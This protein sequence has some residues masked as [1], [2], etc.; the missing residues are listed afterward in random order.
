MAQRTLT[1]TGRIEDAAG[2]GVAGAPGSVQILSPTGAPAIDGN[3]VEVQT[4]ALPFAAGADGSYS[5]VVLYPGDFQT[6]G[7]RIR[8]V[9]N[10]VTTDSPL[11]FSYASSI[12]VSSWY[13]AAPTT[14]KVRMRL[15]YETDAGVPIAGAKA[16]IQISQM[17]VDPNGAQ[18]A[19]SAAGSVQGITDS[20]GTVAFW[21]WPSSVLNPATT[22]Y[23]ARIAGESG[24]LT[25]L[26]PAAADY[27]RGQYDAGTTYSAAS[28]TSSGDVAL[29]GGVLYR[30]INATPSAGHD[31]ATSPTYWQ[32]VSGLPTDLITAHLTA[33]AAAGTV[34]LG[35]GNIVASASITALADDPIATPA[36]LDDDLAILAARAGLTLRTITANATMLATDDWVILDAS[37]GNVT[38]TLLAASARVRPLRI[39]RKDGTANTVSIARAGSDVI[40]GATSLALNTQYLWAVLKPDTAH[41]AWYAQTGTG[42]A[43]LPISAE[44][45]L[46]VGN[47]AG[48]ATR[49][50]IGAAGQ[51]PSPVG[52]D[53]QW[54]TPS[55]RGGFA[56]P[57]T[58]DG[59]LLYRKVTLRTALPIGFLG[60]SITAGQGVSPAPPATCAADLTTASVTITGVNEGVSGTQTAD[61]L[62]G[63]TNDANALVAFA[64]CPIVHIMLGTNDARAG[65]STATYRA[66][67][68]SIVNAW[69]G[70]GKIVVLSYP[71]YATNALYPP[72]TLLAYQ[73]AITSLVD[74]VRVRQGDT[75]GYC[76]FQA[77][78]SDLQ[79]DGIHPNQ[80]GANDLAQLWANALRG[81]VQ[82]LTEQTTLQ[83]LHPTTNGYVLTLAGG[84]PAW[85]APTGGGAGGS[86]TLAGDTD[87]AI[88]SPTNGQVLAYNSTSGKWAN[89]TNPAGF[90]DPTT[91]KGDL[92]VHG[93][94]TARLGVGADGQVLMADST[95][96]AGVKW[97]DAPAHVAAVT[98]DTPGPVFI[99]TGDGQCVLT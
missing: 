72:A 58:Q 76:Y 68:R 41:A 34:A 14:G 45:D 99:V 82:A 20:T 16:T 79:A 69:V 87:V 3:G 97:A 71:I 27:Y 31:P 38:Y 5:Q 9:E 37:A 84:Y 8:I 26:A 7:C 24:T 77:R 10:G 39:V 66:N 4:A 12:A 22:F 85:Q 94:S 80:T 18:V 53:V 75:S 93:A 60:D 17:A 46:V 25:F 95:Q 50:P 32:A 33:P 86:S 59:D 21:V 67:L 43:A 90:A 74:G 11:G 15:V 2:V 78:T 44:G 63:S 62:P 28:G 89:A 1:I 92:I 30:Y 19:S 42:G 13:T 52:A 96:A 98:G 55:D 6:A 48:A 83:A 73:A 54:L 70:R 47:S 51:V 65:A 35:T 81:V 49:L 40:N 57:T 61:W 91:T 29:S 56:D 36:T 64:A 23:T 88:S